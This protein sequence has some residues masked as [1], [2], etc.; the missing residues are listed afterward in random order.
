MADP[1]ANDPVVA[2]APA[3]P[4]ASDPLVAPAP[5]LGWGHQQPAPPALLDAEGRVVQAVKQGWQQGGFLTPE[6]EQDA[7][8]SNQ[9]TWMGRNVVQ[10][11]VDLSNVPLRAVNALGAGLGQAAYEG[12]AAVGGPQLGRD[13]FMLNQLLPEVTRGPAL[14]K[15]QVPSV[16]TRMATEAP[17]P[18]RFVQEHFGEGTPE[19][20]LG[21]QT[22]LQQVTDAVRRAGYDQAP[23]P[24]D[25]APPTQLP[26]QPP[27]AFVP[28]GT[29]AYPPG[30]PRAVDAVVPSAPATPATPATPGGGATPVPQTLDEVLAQAKSVAQQHYDI[31]KAQADSAYT[32]QSVNR[33]V[34]AVDSVAPQGPGER[35]VGGDDAVTRL[36][37]DMQPLRDQ[38]LTLADI[39]RMDERMGDAITVELRA[40]RNKVAQNLQ[41]IQQAWRDQA[42]AVTPADVTGG[43]DGYQALDPARQAWAQYRK[44][45]DVQH[46]KDRADGTQNP[47][48]S[49][50]T[51]VNNFVNGR[52]SRGWTDEE[53][54]ALKDSADR[55]AIGGT[56]HVLG[57]RLLPHVGGVIGAHFGGVT[58]LMAGEVATHALGATARTL[59][60]AMQTSRVNRIAGVLGSGVPA[61]PN[62]LL[63]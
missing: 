51:A 60:N 10:P 30:T 17:S 31:A 29:S 34:D 7:R 15:S 50:R 13:A 56:L 14:V 23:L 25:Q 47:T 53:I 21:S 24:P 43:T 58:G 5:G 4:W 6:A 9:G 52:A 1:W 11:L 41:D 8:A 39:Q 61:P 40:G 37:R 12:A 55:G 33:M 38:P 20:P 45:G 48:S 35:A 62:Q 36:Q 2:A 19:N 16:E 28:P 54:A 26:A 3:A 44:L 63:Y 27:P 49:Y 32:P 42:D 46:M 22:L 59:A 57:S 18:P